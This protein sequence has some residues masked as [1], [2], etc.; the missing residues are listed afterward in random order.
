MDGNA[1]VK[2]SHPMWGRTHS[3]EA[4]KKM[5][6]A[7][8]GKPAH[9]K[10]KIASAESRKR[11]SEAKRGKPAP[12]KGKTTSDETKKK[13]SEVSRN[14]IWITNGINSMRINKTE[15]IP[16]GY[17]RGRAITSFSVFLR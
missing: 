5:S 8:L 4:K 2:E 16:Y 13:L 6:L 12:N 7:K 10:G 11:M 9:N 3:D 1:F 15:P 14:K 17:K